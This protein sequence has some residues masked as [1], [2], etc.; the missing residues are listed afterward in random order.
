MHTSENL[1]SIQQAAYSYFQD[2]TPATPCSLGEQ[3][4]S[5][6]LLSALHIPAN[7]TD[8]DGIVVPPETAESTT[9]EAPAAHCHGHRGDGVSDRT[10]LLL[11]GVL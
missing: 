11:A 9:L 6:T 2:L 3:S 8:M 7:E 5:G 4:S 10:A 1:S